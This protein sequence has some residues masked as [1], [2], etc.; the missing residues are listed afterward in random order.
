MRFV[1]LLLFAFYPITL[2]AQTSP[3]WSRVYTFDE[4]TIDINTALITRIDKDVTRFRFRWTFDKPELSD[5][6]TYQSQLEVVEFNCSKN[7]YRPYHLTLLDTAGNIVRIQ[8]TP[9]KWRTLVSGSMMEKLFVPACELIK[10]K[11]PESRS[12]ES[13]Q[14]ERAANFAHDFAQQLQQTKDFK[15]LIER[16]FVAEYLDGYL[17]DEQTNWFPNLSRDAASKT[18]HKD[19]ERFYIAL[20]NTDYLISLYFIS[21]FRSDPSSLD[22]LFP[23]DVLQL[24][25]QHPYTAQ[26]QIQKDQYDFLGETID[27]VER[28]RGY[29]DLLEKMT[30]L[31][32]AHVTTIKAEETRNWRAT[33]RRWQLYQPKSRVCATKCLGLPKGTTIFNVD[34]PV[35][36]LQ[37]AEIGGQL[38]IVSATNR[39]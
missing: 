33:L 29:T 21:Q 16:F 8:D 5:G 23:P 32:R 14:L 30:S 11:T 15:P 6:L 24:I 10:P 22:K 4:S 17:H 13:L 18:P 25:N 2:I 36:H 1:L 20:M 12:A 37:L 35:F 38:K 28:L 27:N 19:L 34:V 9:G 39:F 3:E 26:Y 7:Q 31:M